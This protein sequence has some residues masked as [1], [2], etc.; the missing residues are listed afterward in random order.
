LACKCRA[1]VFSDALNLALIGK[2]GEYRSLENS[3]ISQ[4]FVAIMVIL[5]RYIPTEVK[6]GMEAYTMGLLAH[7]EFG[8]DRSLRSSKFGQPVH[9]A[10][11]YV[12]CRTSS[13]DQQLQCHAM[14]NTDQA[15]I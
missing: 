14:T 5:L 15:K 8:A 10:Y 12:S 13:V 1:W 9:T 4:I 2:G 7:A 6:F 3:A 11:S